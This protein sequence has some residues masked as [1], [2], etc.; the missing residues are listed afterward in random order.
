MFL[1]KTLNTPVDKV[2][3]TIVQV[4]AIN[5]EKEIGKEAAK[6]ITK[7]LFIQQGR[8]SLCFRPQ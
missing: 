7:E 8:D 3:Y 4:A 2:V 1:K 6:S 5:A